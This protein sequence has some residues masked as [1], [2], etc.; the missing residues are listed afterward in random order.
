MCETHTVTEPDCRIV[1]TG[2]AC[3]ISSR[4]NEIA[5]KIAKQLK[6]VDDRV[7][8]G[9]IPRPT[10]NGDTDQTNLWEE[11]VTMVYFLFWTSEEKKEMLLTSLR[12][13]NFL[14]LRQEA[15]SSV[16]VKLRGI[17]GVPFGTVQW[18]PVSGEWKDWEED[19][20]R[21]KTH[22][23]RTVCVGVNA[24]NVTMELQD[25]NSVSITGSSNWLKT[26]ISSW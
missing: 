21:E 14:A 19:W 13:A 7:I 26:N 18:F 4:E 8:H 6:L 24:L 5:R 3:T 23:E 11:R 17:S 20:K 25:T 10:R 2:N 15:K 16:G 9:H 1:L 22:W 12:G